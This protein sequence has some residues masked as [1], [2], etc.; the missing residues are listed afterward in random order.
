MKNFNQFISNGRAYRKAFPGGTSEQIAHYCTHTLATDHPDTVIINA[1]SNDLQNLEC[2]IIMENILKI[3]DLCRLH[4]VNKIFV[5]SMIYREGLNHKVRELNNLLNHN[6]LE[7]GYTLIDNTNVTSYHIWV[8]KIHPNNDGLT[9][10]AN[11]FIN[12][13]NKYNTT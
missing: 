9:I 10:I 4:G 12:A 8:D 6:Q 2:N 11:N 7:N 3:V 13:I 1:G 5:S